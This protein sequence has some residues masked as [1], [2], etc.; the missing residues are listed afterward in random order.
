MKDN[1]KLKRYKNPEKQIKFIDDFNK[2]KYKNF[3]FRLHKG[4]DDE[5]IEEIIN[6]DVSLTELI[7]KWYTKSH[8]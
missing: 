2:K 3:S 5:I 1:S 8:L 4:R 7:R 6:R